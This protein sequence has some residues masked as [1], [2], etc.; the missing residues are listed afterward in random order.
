MPAPLG[1]L[2]GE[3]LAKYKGGF[4]IRETARW[5]IIPFLLRGA[6]LRGVRALSYQ[7]PLFLETCMCS[8][9]ME[10]PYFLKGVVALSLLSALISWEVYELFSYGVPLFLERCT[11]P[12][13]LECPYFEGVHF[14]SMLKT[15]STGNCLPHHACGDQSFW[16]LQMRQF[17]IY[18]GATLSRKFLIVCRKE[19]TLSNNF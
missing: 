18:P 14:W 4:A 3:G 19:T 7:V 12:F 17:R 5:E 10:C 15:C 8:S 1:R 6:F 9:L 2:L 16:A 13:L 11:C